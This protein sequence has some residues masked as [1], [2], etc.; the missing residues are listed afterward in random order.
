MQQISYQ[1]PLY[2]LNH[3]FL[4][5]FI[6]ESLN[7]F[8]SEKNQDCTKI[9]FMFDDS[10]IKFE[11]KV[12]DFFSKINI[13]STQID[14]FNDSLKGKN[15]H[16]EISFSFK[17]TIF[18]KCPSFDNLHCYSLNFYNTVFKQ[19]A[20]IRWITAKEI[21]YSPR[22]LDAD[23][24]FAHE[25]YADIDNK[26]LSVLN[27]SSIQKLKFRHN[28]EGNGWTYFIGLHITEKADFTNT[29]LNKVHFSNM[30]MNNCYFANAII[31]DTRFINCNFPQMKDL[32]TGAMSKTGYI[33]ND[34]KRYG[35]IATL[36]FFSTLGV[37]IWLLAHFFESW[38]LISILLIF[39]IPFFNY[40]FLF[41]YKYFLGKNK[42]FCIHFA[43]ADEKLAFEEKDPE[44]FSKN[45]NLLR[46]VYRQLRTNLEKNNDF[47]KAGEFYFSQRHMELALFD[48]EDPTKSA[49]QQLLMH[50]LHWINGFG[51]RWVRSFVWLFLTIIIFSFVFVPNKDFVATTETPTFMLEECSPGIRTS[52]NYNSITSLSLPKNTKMKF[53]NNENIFYHLS[54]DNTTVK[55]EKRV[56][57]FD[58]FD[59]FKGIK[60]RLTYSLSHLVAPFTPDEKK[61][62][63]THSEKAYI[64]GFLETI[65]LWLFA[66]AG[67]VAINNRIKR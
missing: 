32:W 15:T 22:T 37:L 24:T 43:T 36:L 56:I 45:I 39:A 26:K 10:T 17:N 35:F 21:D 38:I 8:F 3:K 6:E 25:G 13:N 57:K 40:P 9:H 42:H 59:I 31:Q 54:D 66:F 5:E 7:D 33:S 58:Q 51:E 29:V 34:P 67:A 62:F 53:A 2:P 19:G 49:M 4:K 23:V 52:V 41:I 27:T 48:F 44:L 18:E 55:I 28:L 16:Y 50:S 1:A 65:L 61:W 64:L 60:V 46:E 63:T 11:M 14:D 20:K 12:L 30:N 47:Q